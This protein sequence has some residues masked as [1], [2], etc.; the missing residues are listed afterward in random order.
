VQ[1][2]F[3]LKYLILNSL[4]YLNHGKLIWKKGFRII[5]WKLAFSRTNS[6]HASII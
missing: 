1:F 4:Y 3:K 5:Y 6:I 2:K